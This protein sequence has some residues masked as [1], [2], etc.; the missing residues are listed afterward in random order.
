MKRTKSKLALKRETL[1][2]LVDADLAR[3]PGANNGLPSMTWGSTCVV[4]GQDV[5]EAP[6]YDWT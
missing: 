5:K 2:T 4:N 3:V 6:S 1:R